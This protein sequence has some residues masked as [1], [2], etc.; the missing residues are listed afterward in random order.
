MAQQRQPAIDPNR[1]VV[2]KA[3]EHYLFEEFKFRSANRLARYSDPMVLE[4]Q[5][6]T[7]ENILNTYKRNRLLNY[8]E[9]EMKNHLRHELKKIKAKLKPNIF[10]RIRYAGVVDKPLRYLQ[11]RYYSDRSYQDMSAQYL[12]SNAVDTNTVAIHSELKSMGINIQK[13]TSLAGFLN[14]GPKEFAFH[15]YDIQNPTVDYLVHVKRIPDT[16]AYTIDNVKVSVFNHPEDVRQPDGQPIQ[17]MTFNRSSEVKFDM[18]EMEALTKG[19]ALYTKIGGQDTFVEKSPGSEQGIRQIPFNIHESLDALAIAGYHDVS[20][21]DELIRQLTQGGSSQVYLPTAGNTPQIVTLQ[22]VH[23]ENIRQ[24][25]LV[26]TNQQSH[27][28]DVPGQSPNHSTKLTA[29]QSE[30]LSTARSMV[31]QMKR[32]TQSRRQRPSIRHVRARVS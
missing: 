22:L 28:I 29:S 10:N 19:K 18:A 4:N 31:H 26:A 24:I 21:R 25:R 17:T 1:N 13:E 32:A 20:S 12:V 27:E 9:K 30:Q 3:Y 15:V 8:G 16:S 11:K 7:I 14:H 2:L 5:K 6:M 23:D